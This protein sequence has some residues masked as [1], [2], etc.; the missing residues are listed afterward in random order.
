MTDAELD[1]IRGREQ[2]ATPGPWE[3]DTNGHY[4]LMCHE[5]RHYCVRQGASPIALTGPV[6]YMPEQSAMDGDFIAHA[7]EDVPKLLDALDAARN[8]A[9]AWKR[10]WE[11]VVSIGHRPHI[12]DAD[13][14]A[15]GLIDGLSKWKDQQRGQSD[16]F[17]LKWPIDGAEVS[18]F[19]ALHI[20]LAVERRTKEL[21]AKI[22]ELE[23]EK[24]R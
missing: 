13:L 20:D 5:N 2:R 4:T 22:V 1:E 17:M 9:Q 23:S 19:L 7:R 16:L 11:R 21:T 10:D 8:E 6:G 15:Q 24:T 18:R 12:A 14:I 3:F